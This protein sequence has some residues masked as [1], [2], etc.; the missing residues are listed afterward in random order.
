MR[1]KKSSREQRG[2]HPVTRNPN[3][4]ANS[5]CLLS[6]RTLGGS[7]P[8]FGAQILKLLGQEEDRPRHGCKIQGCK[9]ELPSEVPRQDTGRVDSMPES[10][11]AQRN[12]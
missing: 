11:L 4:S 10:K 9:R 3:L 12:A 6:G 2:N 7:I 5:H 1:I 8:E